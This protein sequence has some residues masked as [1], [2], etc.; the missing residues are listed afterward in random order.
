[1][2]AH[3]LQFRSGHTLSP[4]SAGTDLSVVGAS[5]H[6]V[7]Y[8]PH[9]EQRTHDDEAHPSGDQEHTVGAQGRRG[10]AREG[11]ADRHHG[12]GARHVVRV[13]AVE[14]VGRDLGLDT[15]RPHHAPEGHPRPGDGGSGRHGRDVEARADRHGEAGEGEQGDRA[16]AEHPAGAQPQGEQAAQERCPR[17]ARS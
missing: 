15:G 5:T 7:P 2:R 6:Q 13:D 9:R 3:R 17:R 14:D 12:Q 10:R 4:V 16:G 11:L 1:M 8:R